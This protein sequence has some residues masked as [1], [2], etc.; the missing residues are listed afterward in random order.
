M[1]SHIFRR[2]GLWWARLVVPARLR[3]AAGRREF[4][5]SCRTHEVSI[6]KMVASVLVAD[7]RQRLLRLESVPMT[8]DVLKL[9]EGSPA[10]AGDGWVPMPLAV[11]LTGIGM[12]FLLSAAAEGNLPLF[13]RLSRVRGH[14]V[15]IAALEPDDPRAGRDGGVVIPSP[16]SMP[17]TA[18]ASTQTG[19]LPLCNPDLVASS[20]LAG[21][22]SSVDLVAL[23]L[24]GQPG[25][26]FAPDVVLTVSVEKLEVRASALETLRQK[27]AQGVSVDAIERARQIESAAAKGNAASMGKKAHKLY[28]EALEAYATSPSGIP[29]CVASVAE[30]KQKRRGCDLFVELVGDMPIADITADHLREFRKKLKLLPAKANN[31]PKAYRRETMAATVKA[32]KD[33]GEAWGLMSEGAQHERMQWLDQ[34]FRWLA[35]QGD[36]LKDNPM[37]SVLGEQTKTAAERKTARQEKALRRDEGVDDDSDDREPFT[38]DELRLIFG[39]KHYQTGHGVHV[40]GNGVWYPF[41]YWLPIIGLYAGCRIKEVSQLY[42]SDIRQSTEGDW[43]FD[44]NETTSDKSLK[45]ANATRQI[46][47]SPLLIGLGLPEYC[48]RL[49]AEG[50]QRLFPELSWSTS[51]A[52][53]AKESK[54]KM[55]GSFE[56]LGM[57]RDGSKVFHCLRANF[58]DAVKR[59]PFSSLPFDDQDLKT[60]IRQKILGHKLF[61]VN[62][63]HYTSTTMREKLAVV[64]SIQYDLPELVK[65]DIEF[66]IQQVRVGIANKNGF[67]KGRE[68][69]GPLNAK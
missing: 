59:V 39:V 24:P 49:K 34:M 18:L 9:I 38:P 66:G 25:M 58:N 40:K 61:G 65:F 51:D 20:I 13:C 47:M 8:I 10:L 62:D 30:Q 12:E 48:K 60:F 3:E 1:S 6:A 29:G 5:Q 57:E 67:R 42:L 28:S 7:W 63:L 68:D 35:A 14:Q 33:A 64:Q 4:I 31:I 45:N 54:R 17:P 44:I 36:W 43:Y 53:Y 22:L 19:V 27:M 41:E 69:M 16:E 26:L 56:A 15:A 37:A 46:P 55:S 32:L 52:K 2:G 50:Y 11:D 21:C 23:D